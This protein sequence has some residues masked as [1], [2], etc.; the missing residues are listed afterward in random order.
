MKVVLADIEEKALT[1]TENDVKAPGAPKHTSSVVTLKSGFT[2]RY[3]RPPRNSNWKFVSK[4][5]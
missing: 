5:N 3:N 4:R 1:E 2:S